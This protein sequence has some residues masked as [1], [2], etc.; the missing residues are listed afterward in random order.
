[1]SKP[2]NRRT[3][4]VRP[5]RPATPAELAR[6]RFVRRAALH[7]LIAICFVGGFAW[8]VG[9]LRQVVSAK[10]SERPPTVTFVNRPAWMTDLVAG[11]LSESFRPTAG[12]S[13]FDRDALVHVHQRLKASPWVATV[14]GVRRVFGNSPGDTIEVD[15]DF[16]TPVALVND[17]EGHYWFVDEK[18]VKLPEWFDAEQLGKVIF[19]NGKVNLRIIEGVYNAPPAEAGK[20]WPG[21]D[22]IAGIDLAKLLHGRDFTE[23]IIRI[24]VSNYIGRMNVREPQIV[25]MTRYGTQVRWGNAIGRSD[26]FVELPVARKLEAM[27]WVHS[28]YGRVDNYKPWIDIRFETIAY[29]APA[30]TQEGAHADWR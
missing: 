5:P 2:V 24:N 22:L 12:S 25:L 1:M 21:D 10:T 7:T 29:P 14:R 4:D 11:N 13:V 16:R 18:G 20:I 6:A 3:R 8:M 27:K 30:A 23:D 28:T 26:W 9:S 17:N 15:C 19:A